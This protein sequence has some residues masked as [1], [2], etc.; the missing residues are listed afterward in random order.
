MFFKSSKI[1]I[2]ISD[3][4]RHLMQTSVGAVGKL[5]GFNDVDNIRSLTV[6]L[7]YF[8]AVAKMQMSGLASYET[9]ESIMNKSVDLIKNVVGTK[10][11]WDSFSYNFET[12]YN[13]AYAN[14]KKSGNS[15]NVFGDFSKLYVN[16]LYQK[17]ITDNTIITVGESLTKQIYELV[18]IFTSNIKIVK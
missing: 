14:L 7:A 1:K 5:R 9:I 6:N 12:S 8:Y 18:S 3:M 16:D 11:G 13:N 10:P 15:E 4:P 2:K 17:E